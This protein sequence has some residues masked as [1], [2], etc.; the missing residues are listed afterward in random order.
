[1]NHKI[2]VRT[3]TQSDI[4]ALVKLSYQK[5][6]AYEMAQPQFWKYAENAEDIQAKWFEELL[7][8]AQYIMLVDDNLRAFIIGRLI[9]APEVYNPGG[10]AVMID[11][12]CVAAPEFW[13]T[14]GSALVSKVKGIAKKKGAT[15]ILVV[16]G[17]HDAAKN[18][19]IEACGLNITSRWYTGEII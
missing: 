3:V 15:Q 10:L 11:D 7:D 19:F 18:Q 1:M 5:R 9:K 16:S 17:D 14:I 13:H 8:D 4:P 6:R 2:I 12:F